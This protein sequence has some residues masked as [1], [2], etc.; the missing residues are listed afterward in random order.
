MVRT[1]HSLTETIHT[2]VL[3]QE[4]LASL[5]VAYAQ[6]VVDGTLGGA[7]HAEALA[8]MM[9]KGSLFIGMDRDRDALTRAEKRLAHV[10][11]RIVFKESNYRTLKVALAGLGVR[12][13][14][15]LLDLGFSSDQLERSGRGFSFE[16]DEP[17]LMTLSAE[18]K[19][20]EVTAKEAVNEWSE[21]S[22]ADVIYGF[23]GERQARRIARAIVRA[24]EEVPIET[25]AQLAHVIERAVHRRGKVHPAT[26][27]FQALR[28]AVNDE[29]GALEQLLGDVPELLTPGGRVAIISFHSLEDRLVKHAFRAYEKGGVGTTQKKPIVPSPEEVA[30]NPRA[31][32]A[33]LRIL[34]KH[35]EVPTTL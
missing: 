25:S 1:T 9:A 5:D 7:G 10:P 2:P 8:R 23:G 14:A 21:E 33:R 11:P 20:G 18:T 32:S 26:R 6:V 22:L 28:I 19:M 4:V 29:L 3:L 30:R 15:V 35:H 17:L 31:R 27:T 16:R 34:F 12:A 13:D 24:R